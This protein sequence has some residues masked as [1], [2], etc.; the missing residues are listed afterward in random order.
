MMSFSARPR[1]DAPGS[2]PVMNETSSQPCSPPKYLSATLA[3][4]LMALLLGVGPLSGLA[5]GITATIVGS[6]KDPQ[7]SLVPGATVKV[8][9]RRHGAHTIRRN[10]RRR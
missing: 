2:D 8:H 1:L 7:G 9:Q 10:G 5:Q 4:L 3:L 6:V